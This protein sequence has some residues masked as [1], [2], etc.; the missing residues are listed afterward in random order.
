L[1][2]YRVSFKDAASLAKTLIVEVDGEVVG[3]LMPQI[4]DGWA[5]AEVADQARGTNA[6]LGWVLYPD[7]AGRGYATEA[8]RDLLR[9]C[10]TTSDYAASPRTASPT[11]PPRGG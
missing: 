3:D 11:T 10:F 5:Q 6:E 1:E 7:R 8:V 9:L 4:E 2:E